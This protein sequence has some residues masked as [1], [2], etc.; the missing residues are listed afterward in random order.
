MHVPPALHVAGQGE[1]EGRRGS[2][3]LPQFG[4]ERQ[5]LM[6]ADVGLFICF[7][8]VQVKP[9]TIPYGAQKLLTGVGAAPPFLTMH[10]ERSPCTKCQRV[11]GH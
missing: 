4:E 10:A 5:Q 3:H 1:A 11:A 9:A 7:F 6:H 8:D 2:R